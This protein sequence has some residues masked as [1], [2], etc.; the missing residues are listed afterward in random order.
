M[1]KRTD[2]LKGNNPAEW[3]KIGYYVA[4]GVGNSMRWLREGLLSSAPMLAVGILIMKT[5]LA[6]MFMGFSTSVCVCVCAI[7]GGCKRVYIFMCETVKV[8]S[9]GNRCT[10]FIDTLDHG[11]QRQ[12][13]T[14]AHVSNTSTRRDRGKEGWRAGRGLMQQ[15]RGIKA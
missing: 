7:K 9:E 5:P 2:R 3:M 14:Y 12:K 13:Q 1:A 15:Y 6:R 8:C 4:K 11:N 10:L